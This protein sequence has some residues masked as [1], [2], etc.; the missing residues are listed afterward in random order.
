MPAAL[1]GLLAWLAVLLLARAPPADGCSCSPI[2]PQ[3]AFCNA[4]VG[5]RRRRRR[6]RFVPAEPRPGAAPARPG[7]ARPAPHSLEPPP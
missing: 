3:Q 5:E 4:D 6:A 1:P 7:P 2:H